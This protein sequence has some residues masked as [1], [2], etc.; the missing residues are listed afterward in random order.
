MR[1]RWGPN[2]ENSEESPIVSREVNIEAGRN[3]EDEG[4]SV[5]RVKGVSVV[6]VNG[7]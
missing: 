6:R 3:S 7:V 2:S 5:M 1:A 4:V